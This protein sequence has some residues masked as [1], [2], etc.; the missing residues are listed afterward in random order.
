MTV[1]G[2]SEGAV[3]WISG[4]FAKTVRELRPHGMEV[5]G[6]APSP[7]ARAKGYYRWQIIFKGLSVIRMNGVLR[8]ALKKV[9]PGK[10]V[11]IVVDADP[12]SML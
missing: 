10:G 1:R 12:I 3:K 2:R 8:E 6:P 9:K 5:L 11:Q 7:I 4:Y